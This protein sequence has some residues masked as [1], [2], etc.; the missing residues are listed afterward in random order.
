M[1]GKL[2]VKDNRLDIAIRLIDQANGAD[3]RIVVS[4]GVERPAELVYAERMS[5]KLD[6]FFPGAPDHLRIAIRAQHIERWTSPRKSYAEGRAGYLKWRQD[7]KDFHARRAGD[8][9][10]E[11]GYKPDEIERVGSLIRKERMKR[12]EEAQTVEDVAC[13]VFLEYYAA[14]FIAG[15]DD[16]KIIDILRKTARKMSARGLEAAAALPLTGRLGELLE[17][18]LATG[19]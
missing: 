3:P 6:D 19:H 4:D 10:R 7:L 18:A 16:E 1:M 5:R 17:K 14:E 13:L 8:L 9:M 12:D 15:H 11:A 2:P